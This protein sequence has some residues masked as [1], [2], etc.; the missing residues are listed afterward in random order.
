MTKAVTGSKVRK[1]TDQHDLTKDL[2]RRHRSTRSTGYEDIPTQVIDADFA[3]L[4][5]NGYVIIERLLDPARLQAVREAAAAHMGATGRTTFEG[6]LTQRVYDVFS[7]TRAVDELAEHPRVLAL[8]DR[9]FMP[10]YL[11]SQAQIINILPGSDPQLLHHDDGSYPSPRPRPPLG[12]ATIWAIDDFT[13]TNGATAVIPGGH[14]WGEDRVPA[15]SEA[16]PCV[17]PAGSVVLFLGTLWHGGGRN[18]SESARLAVTCQYCEPWLR[19]QENFTL[20]ISRQ[21]AAGLSENLLRMIGYSVLPPFYGMVNGMHPKRLLEEF[22][23][24]QQPADGRS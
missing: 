21:T 22:G 10:N 6:E 2:A 8:L 14:E 13:S 18:R 7:K 15:E 12:A 9:L 16:I 3:R 19:Q 4:M 24:A 11:L 23:Y 20:E 1:I 5:R 17:M